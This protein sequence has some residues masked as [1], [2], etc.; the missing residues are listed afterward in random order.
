MVEET[1]TFCTALRFVRLNRR[2]YGILRHSPGKSVGADG[3]PL[4][5]LDTELS[6]LRV[7]VT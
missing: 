7:K 6:S 1:G 2:G 5:R 3:F 4:S